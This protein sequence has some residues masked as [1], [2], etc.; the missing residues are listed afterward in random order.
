MQVIQY[1]T[2]DTVKLRSVQTGELVQGNKDISISRIKKIER[3]GVSVYN[4]AKIPEQIQKS[5][6]SWTCTIKT[7]DRSL[8]STILTKIQQAHVERTFA[9]RRPIFE[10]KSGIA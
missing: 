4:F 5:A 7:K 1:N 8:L 3:Y 6:F 2:N 10:S 9:K